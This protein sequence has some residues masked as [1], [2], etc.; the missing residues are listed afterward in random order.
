[1]V[2]AA[3]ADVTSAHILSIVKFLPTGKGIALIWSAV[4]ACVADVIEAHVVGI[5]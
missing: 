4:N 1:L 5:V 3:L 2:Q